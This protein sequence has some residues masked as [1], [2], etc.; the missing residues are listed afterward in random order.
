MTSQNVLSV[1][2]GLNGG[3]AVLSSRGDI[4][5]NFD[6]PTIGDGARRR[7][8]AA[9]LADAFREHGPYAFAIVEQVGAMPGNGVSSMFRF[10][11]AYGTI[12]GVVG[13]LAIPV[14]H[15][16]PAKWKKALGLNAEAEASRAR[17]IETWPTHADMFARKRDHNRAEAALLALYALRDGGPDNVLPK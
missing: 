7:V 16:S 10:G 1:D 9:N 17:A 14:R 15:V 4:L 13:A 11:Q 2:P 6:L 8:D 3:A 12:L 5:A